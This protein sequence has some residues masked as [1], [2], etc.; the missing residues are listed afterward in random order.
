MKK[1]FLSILLMALPLLASAYDCQVDGFYYN[2]IPEGI[3]AQVTSGDTHYSGSVVIPEKFT[4]EGVEYSVISIG[5]RAFEWCSGLTSVT[6]PNSVTS[7]GYSAFYYC[8]GLTSVTIPNSVTSIG[9][10]AFRNCIGLTSITIPNSVTSIGD[11]AFEGC[12]RL[13]TVTIPNSVTSIGHSAF[14]GCSGLTSITIPN[15]VTHIGDNAF[16]GCSGL[17]SIIVEDG[18]PNYDSRD[19]CNAI[20]ET[21]TNNLI[22]GCMNTIIPNTVTAIGNLAFY[23]C[24]GLISVTIPNSVTSIGFG[25]FQNCTGLTSVII[26]NSV[27]SIGSGAFEGCHGLTSVTI[28]KSVTSI[29][30]G[31]YSG[32]S[33]LSSIIVEDGNPNYDSRDNCNAI[34]ETETNNLIKGCMNTIIPST[35]TSIEW[36]AFYNCTGLTS[37]TIPNSVTRIGDYAFQCCRNLTSVTIPNSMTYIGLFAFSSCS[38]LTSVISKMENP[39]SIT[40]DIFSHPFWDLDYYDIY[41]DATLYVPEGTIDKYKST[42]YWNKFVHIEEWEPSDI[43]IINRKESETANGEK[44]YDA[45]GNK[46][47]KSQRG[48]NIIRMND[49]TVKKVVVK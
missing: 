22:N 14:S 10:D 43:I 16:S 25:A 11:W 3:L 12:S 39:C 2:L 34:I 38:S 23:D 49:G 44:R 33:S 32:C 17:T 13:T 28:P 24:R 18:N 15:S 36:N 21:E 30:H 19:Y 41:C 40:D 46:I 20:I 8:S 31:A 26:P 7:I 37:I 5:E 42:N 9:N 6:I 35:V 1:L 45:S 48:L 27:T 29:G 4:Y 47:N